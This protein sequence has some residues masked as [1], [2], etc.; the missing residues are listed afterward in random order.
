[1][2]GR[3]S[4]FVGLLLVSTA[5]LAM[6]QALVYAGAWLLSYGTALSAAGWAVGIGLVVGGSVWGQ[7]LQRKAM[8]EQEAAA[9][10]AYNASLKDRTATVITSEHPHVYV[11]GQSVVVGVRV[12]DVLTSGDRDQYH[13]LVCVVA[14]HESDAILDVA[15]NDKWLGALDANGNVTTGEYLYG[16]PVDV[17]EYKSGT[18]FTLAYTPKAGGLRI[19]YWEGSADNGTQRNMPYTLVGAVVTVSSSHAFTCSYQRTKYTPRVRVRQRLGAPATP[20]DALTLAEIAASPTPS[21]YTSTCTMDEKTGLIIRLDLDHAEFQGGLPSIKVKMN[22]KKVHDVRDPAWPDDVPAVSSNNALCIAD[23]L[24]SEMCRV[25]V[26]D[27]P[28]ADYIAAAN[29]CD[30]LINIGGQMLPRYTLNGTVRSDQDRGQV[31]ESMALSMAGSICPTTW[32]IHAGVWEAPVMALT[33][34]DIWG[35]FNFNPGVD[36]ADLYNGIKGQFV[37]AAN[38]WVAT[39]YKPYRNTAYVT[40]DGGRELWNPVDFHFTDDLQRVHNLCRILTE[41]HR[42]AFS[43]EGYFSFKAWDLPQEGKR[44]T[45]TS[46]FLGQTT[47]IYR[48]VAKKVGL[49]QLVWLKMKE[50]AATIWDSADAVTPDSTPNTDLPDP[51]AIAPLES[52]TLASG[53]D[54]LQRNSDGTITSRIYASW[55]L[56][57]TQG[58][59][60]GGYVE[61]EWRTSGEGA[62]NKVQVTG[63]DTDVYLSP[64]KDLIYYQVRARTV[65]PVFNLKSIWLYADHLVIGKT[66]PPTAVSAITATPTLLNVVLTWEEIADPDRKDYLI[67]DDTGGGLVWNV[68]AGAQAKLPPA[69]A[70]LH[71]YRIISRDTSKLTALTEAT[72]DLTIEAPSAPVLA[73]AIKDGMVDLTWND[74]TATH[75]VKNYEVRHGADW[76]TGDFVG[77]ADTQS[78][79]IT[80]NWTG[81]RTFH[82]RATDIG[83]NAGAVGSVVVPIVAAAAPALT[84]QIV[85]DQ[86][87]LDWTA[88]TS[89]LP[90]DMYEVRY[91]ASWAAGTSLGFFRI[92]RHS[93]KAVWLGSRTFWVAARDIAGN[94]G[95]PASV[96]AIITA[97]AAPAII[98]EVIDNNVLLR[99]G[100]VAGTL[101]TTG[102]ELRRGSTWAS[103]EPIGQKSGSFTIVFETAAGVYTYWLAA[104]DTA[105]NYGTPGQVV[106][107]VN[108]PPDYVLKADY[109]S[110][111]N[112]TL[113]NL[114]L[115][116][117]VDGSLIGPVNTTE[118]FA[119]HFTT[120]SWTTPQDQIDAGYPVYAQP[121]LSPAY[122]EETIDYGTLLASNRIT[123][124]PTTQDMVGAVAK[125]CTISV[126]DDGV[127]WTDYVGTWQVYATAFQYVKFRITFTASN[128]TD[129]IEFKGVNIRL[130]SKLKTVTRMVS[131][132]SADVSGTVVY[133]TDDWTATG[134]KVFIDVDAITL[135]P[136]GTTPVTAV[137]DFTDAPNPLEVA[138]YL[139]D[140]TGARVSGNC[141]LTVRGF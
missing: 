62:W 35:D 129:L 24:T 53:T 88:P 66:V 139:F 44:V 120:N 6:P 104:I 72:C 21:Q 13:H 98:T 14:D 26:T 76:D 2:R 123:I 94:T 40:A 34:D 17:T 107:T 65:N 22:G 132:D 71:T 45:F 127:S 77:R 95:T 5:A 37:S 119:E 74:C 68:Y 81:D 58:V 16:E 124:T 36:D 111:L 32:S 9:R 80:P 4:L 140:N 63:D 46:P 118:T 87:Q 134:N 47:K 69:S 79:R 8:Q 115:H 78:L 25:P 126:S 3:F 15:I 116:G 42:N 108:Q 83:G 133:L 20:A 33:Q 102:Y 110:L 112:G 131:C 1:M 19:T 67:A 28:Q 64:V 103:G 89:T 100:A 141:S 137:Y 75:Q 29:A 23:Y 10:A 128:T 84:A 31:L 96:E 38:L 73:S 7:S 27:L 51:F 54:H 92:T 52:I 50:D 97:A 105:G 30:A 117:D 113:S 136:Q 48:V 99:W 135:T 90:L 55:P 70:G 138:L 57:T 43:I 39:D 125:S 59:V 18:V 60:H 12:V 82:V 114:A 86:L 101:P 61:V 109:D 49:K 130:D 106:A 56:P 93:L 41:D 91:G 122:Y 121:N 11:Y 85:G